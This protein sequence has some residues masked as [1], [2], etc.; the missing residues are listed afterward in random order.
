MNHIGIAVQCILLTSEDDDVDAKVGFAGATR[1]CHHVDSR[2]GEEGGRGYQAPEV[3]LNAILQS[4][5]L[6]LGHRLL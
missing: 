4:F 2:R 6:P 1:L 3:S 5:S